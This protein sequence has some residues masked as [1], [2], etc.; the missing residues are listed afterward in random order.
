MSSEWDDLVTAALIGTD[1]RQRYEP[2]D[3]LDHAAVLT[4]ARRAGRLP[5][6]LA[7]SGQDTRA[8]VPGP[9]A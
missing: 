5:G 1:R 7:A 6:Q 4:A 9:S 3:L 8:T 2:A